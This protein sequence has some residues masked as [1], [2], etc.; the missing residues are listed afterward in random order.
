MR[1]HIDSSSSLYKIVL[2]L[3]DADHIYKASECL[4]IPKQIE[5]KYKLW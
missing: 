1:R 4:L 5:E 3:V 2:L